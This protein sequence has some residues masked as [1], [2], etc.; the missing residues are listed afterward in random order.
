M[1]GTASR[2][3]R[4]RR[5][6]SDAAATPL[7]SVAPES[8][9][10]IG[11]LAELTGVSPA[12]LRMWEVRYGFPDPARRASGHRR[13]SDDDV[14]DVREI[15][16]MRE[17]GLR[18]DA[19][20]AQVVSRGETQRSVDT[21]TV[22]HRPTRSR[23]E[24][25]AATLDPGEPAPSVFAA[26][27]RLH[28]EISPQRLTKRTLNRLCWGMED[29]FCARALPGEVF[30]FFQHARHYRASRARWGQVASLAHHAYAF[31]QPDDRASEEWSDQVTV[32]DLPADHVMVRE[33]VL[34]C[35]APGS[36]AALVAWEMPGQRPTDDRDRRFEAAWSL[37]PA[38]VRRA[39]QA[40]V[41][42]AAELGAPGADEVADRLSGAPL[43]AAQLTAASSVF[44]RVLAYTEDDE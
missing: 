1:P 13:Y 4:Y 16:R 40:C 27:R 29:E 6:M 11:D 12:T 38:V 36:P 34:V 41:A 14:A 26:I 44:A 32:V 25:G 20:V 10:T 33:W 15:L 18:L 35:D 5:A 24:D 3:E 39:A 19:A 42:V 22:A 30:G 31:A 9:H 2:P 17:E 23:R 21:E 28:P 7:R 8:M 37:D 43:S